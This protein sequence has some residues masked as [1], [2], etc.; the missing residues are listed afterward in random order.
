MADFGVAKLVEGD[1]GSEGPTNP[2]MLV[3][4]PTTWRRSGSGGPPNDGRADI[5]G[6]GVTLC[7]MLAGV[8][9]FEGMSLG[10]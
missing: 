4:L 3:A 1:D 2:S 10:N 5:Y 7:Y 9:S 6:L 8:L